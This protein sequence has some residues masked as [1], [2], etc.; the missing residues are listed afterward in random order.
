MAFFNASS[1][2]LC[3]SLARFWETLKEYIQ[4]NSL[5]PGDVMANQIGSL[6]SVTTVGR[7]ESAQ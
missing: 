6:T 3:A 7:L 2:T 4:G 5:V 1:R